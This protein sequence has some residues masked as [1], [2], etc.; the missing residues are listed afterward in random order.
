MNLKKNKKHPTDNITSNID[1]VTELSKNEAD[2]LRIY[3]SLDFQR[4]VQILSLAAKLEA[5]ITKE[6]KNENN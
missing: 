1:K 2:L 3:D 4:R 6:V 5:E